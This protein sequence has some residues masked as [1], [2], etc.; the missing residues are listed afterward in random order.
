MTATTDTRTFLQEIVREPGQ[1]MQIVVLDKSPSGGNKFIASRYFD[2]AHVED[3]V[4]FGEEHRDKFDVFVGGA[5]RDRDLGDGEMGDADNVSGTYRL[6]LDADDDDALDQL[7]A[8]GFMG[9]PAPTYVVRSGGTTQS[10]RARLQAHWSLTGGIPAA[11]ADRLLK[12]LADRLKGDQQSADTFRILR[13]PGTF[14]FKD[15]TPAPV[16]LVTA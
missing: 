7:D 9:I 1:F 2:A 15:G 16:E 4:A 14:N 8:I 12:A 3:A 5:P 13:F 6:W 10:G 11:K